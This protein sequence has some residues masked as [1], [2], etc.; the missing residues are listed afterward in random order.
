MNTASLRRQWESGQ[1]TYNAFLTIPSPWTAEMMAHAGW[2][3]LT[4]DMQHGLMDFNIT[5]AMLQAMAPTGAVPFVRLPWNEPSVIMKV[6]DAGVQGVICPMINTAEDVERFVE[7]CRYPPRGIR[8]FGPIR[9][10]LYAETENYRPY[11]DDHIL[12]FAM[13]ETA[14]AV[15]NLSEIAAVP[16]LDGLY[17]GPYDLSVSMGLET[18]ADFENPGLLHVLES[19][20]RVCEENDLTP[21]IF[22]SREKDAKRVAAMGFRL[23]SC[24]D[25]TGMFEGAAR[26]RMEAL[27][28]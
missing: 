7:A 4:I 1:P 21:G 12:T 16:E 17:I 3:T 18:V 19:V 2:P 24:G 8:S 26:R 6:L 28:G 14:N 5:L 22:T 25:D 10:R 11:A 15:H 27:K 13:I 23:V 9:A 20:L